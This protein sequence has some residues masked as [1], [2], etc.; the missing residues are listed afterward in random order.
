MFKFLRSNAKFFYWI[1]AATFIGFIF[2]AW[3]MDAAGGRG[4][5]QRRAAVG[6]VN[7]MEISAAVYDRTVRDIQATYRRN[8]PDRPLTANQVALARDQ[9]WDQLVNSQLMREEIERLGLVVTDD[10]MLQIFRESPPPEILQ[11]FTDESGQPDMQ[12]YYAA[13]GDPTSGIDWSQVEAWVRQSVPQQKLIEMITAGVTVSEYEIRQLYIGQAGRAVAEYIGV[14]FADLAADY[15]PA[16]EEILAYYQQHSGEYRQDER[17]TAKVVAWE[18]AP[19]PADFDEVRQL[20]VDLKR[21]IEAG[22]QTFADAASIYSEDGTAEKGGDLGMFDRNRMVAPFTEAAFSLPVGQLSEPVQT[23]FGFHIIEVTDQELDDDG[24]V[25]RVQA[26]HILLKVTPGEATREAIYQRAE[27]FRAA[28]NE[29]NFLTLADQDS[30]CRVLSPRPF[31]EGRDIP[32]VSQSAA[33]SR[34]V[35]RTEPGDIS[36]IFY[37]DDEAYIVMSE[38]IEP[39]GPRPLEEVRSQV[40][41]ALRRQRQEQEA[42]GRLAPAVGRIQMGEAM[43]DVAAELDL[44]H[45]VTDTISANANVAD[46][47][48]ATPFNMVA[49]KA[50]VGELI[51]EVVTNRGLF[52]LE[53]LWQKPFDEEE[54]ASRRERLRMVLLQ[55]EQSRALEAWIEAR[56]EASDIRD[57]RDELA[58]L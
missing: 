23:Q 52:A 36:P 1:I 17:G 48:Y 35:F 16:E 51:P 50:E 12:A 11:A 22:E 47:G 32:G 44:I 37:T 13:L 43:A 57:Y 33:G 19:S 8:A 15:E 24:E 25:A 4:A 54:Y 40:V 41:T 21:S 46:V 38:G 45:A 10:E 27:D 28:A 29:S 7:G 58:S 26:R 9:A 56:R 39:A 31:L 5:A 53:V 6:E 34:F 42:R 14:P 55:Q 20:A 18:V 3:G 2:L 49:L 30:T